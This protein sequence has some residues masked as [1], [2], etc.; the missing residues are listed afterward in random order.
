MIFISHRGNLLGRNEQCENRPDYIEVAI[1]KG[2]YVEIDLRVIDSKLLLG[3]D[4]PQYEINNEFLQNKKLYIH[5]KNDEALQ[6]LNKTNLHYFWH[7]ND[8]YT[9]TS[10]RIVW[11]YPNKKLLINSIVVMP[12]NGQYSEEDINKCFGICSNDIEKYFF[13]FAIKNDDDII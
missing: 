1:Q 5:A 3:H 11:V 13:R 12:E 9:L 8:D 10:K 4:G 7:Q 2:F 6:W